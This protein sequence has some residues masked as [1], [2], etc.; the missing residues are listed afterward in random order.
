MS[1][2][3]IQPEGE[4]YIIKIHGE[5]K[6]ENSPKINSIFKKKKKKI[7]LRKQNLALIK[8]SI[9]F[10]AAL[11]SLFTFKVTFFAHAVAC[12]YE[13]KNKRNSSKLR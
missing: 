9:G 11:Y 2:Q 5:N 4:W 13:E 3:C 7:C 10:Y 8:I 1:T 12:I 6:T